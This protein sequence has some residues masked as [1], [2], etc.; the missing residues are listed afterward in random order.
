MSCQIMKT[1]HVFIYKFFFMV[2]SAIFGW[3]V[4]TLLSL[5]IGVC[6]GKEITS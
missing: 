6:W 2:S 1:Y 5:S 4:T 3:I